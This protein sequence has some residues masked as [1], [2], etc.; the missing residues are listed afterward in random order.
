MWR[1]EDFTEVRRCLGTYPLT[2]VWSL[3]VTIDILWY[4]QHFTNGDIERWRQSSPQL[5]S[6]TSMCND[7]LKNCFIEVP[8]KSNR[9]NLFGYCF[10]LSNI[11]ETS[12]DLMWTFLPMRKTPTKIMTVVRL[13]KSFKKTEKFTGDCEARWDDWQWENNWVSEGSGQK[14][15]SSYE[16]AGFS[17]LSE[18]LL[19]LRR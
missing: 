18:T 3:S 7:F 4:L 19:S 9:V 12:L 8:R 10:F 16:M 17:C 15:Y 11:K 6:N 5:G 14:V 1:S 2:L 13:V